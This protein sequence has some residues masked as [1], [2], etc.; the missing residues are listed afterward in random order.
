MTFDINTLTTKYYNKG[1][2]IDANLLL[3][4]FVGS[5][6]K[7]LI[8]RC[9]RTTRYAIEDYDTLIQY[10]S[11]FST[12]ITTPNIMTEVWSL[13][14]TS[15]KGKYK[16]EFTAV[17][18]NGIQVLPEHFITSVEASSHPKFPRIGLSDSVS[19]ILAK[20]RWLLLTDDFPLSQYCQSLGVDCINFNHLRVMNWK[21]ND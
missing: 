6:S 18:K 17:Y 10:L 19:M 20:D 11:V 1:V 3:L 12:R 21:I 9:D 5:V 7:N 2:L 13:A 16:D 4:L 15:I 14:N 8:E